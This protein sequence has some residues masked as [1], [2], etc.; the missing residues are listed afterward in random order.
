MAPRGKISGAFPKRG[1]LLHDFGI[2]DLADRLAKVRVD[3]CKLCLWYDGTRGRSAGGATEGVRVGR[4]L[5]IP[6]EA[7]VMP[8]AWPTWTLRLVPLLMCKLY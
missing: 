2:S 6:F 3:E 5:H 4:P 1:E 8:L 7:A